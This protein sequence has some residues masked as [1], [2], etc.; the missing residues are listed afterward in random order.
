MT[1][2]IFI[3]ILALLILVHELG[4]FLVAK[5]AGVKVP[6]FGLG[7]P[8]KILGKKIGETEYTLNLIP[9]GGFVKIVGEN[10]EED[11]PPEDRPR[12]FMVQPK[13]VQ[14]AIIVAGVSFNWLFAWILLSAGFMSG[15]PASTETVAREAFV[16]EPVLTITSV[17]PGSPAA[18]SGLRAGDE[19]LAFSSNGDGIQDIKEVVMAQD[20]IASHGNNALGVLYRRGDGA[21]AFAEA[22][23]EAGIVEGKQ[24]IGITM[25]VLGIA[26]YSLPDALWEGL[27]TTSH[28]TVAIATGLFELMTDLVRGN[29]DLSGIAGPVGIAGMV[30]EASTL[31]FIHLL[32]FTALISINLA[33]IN[34]VPFP[35]LD[36]GRL[37]FIVIE[38]IKG[39]PI[40]Q[41]VTQVAN[42][43][44]F[45]LLIGLM[46]LV[47]YNDIAR[48]FT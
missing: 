47:T 43:V 39:S 18:E 32:T 44:G 2:I 31:G 7:F 22:V 4:H 38:A 16:G 13:A 1:I 48:L 12:S 34:L 5:K 28:L 21:P 3:L 23:P 30:G 24:A 20:F 41:K 33:I 42:T 10:A 19:I 37:L 9:F 45:V 40:S 36:G 6:E 46:L 27:R 29:A 17:L 15:L 26:K 11:I 35:A 25:S 14:A 8:P